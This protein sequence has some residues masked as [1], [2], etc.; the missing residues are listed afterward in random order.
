[1]MT[2]SQKFLISLD[3]RKAFE[4]AWRSHLVTCKPDASAFILQALLRGANPR[5]GFAPISNAVKLAN[6]QRAWQGYHAALSKLQR[7]L[8]EYVHCVWPALMGPGIGPT[9]FEA[10]VRD[11]AAL[12]DQLKQE[13]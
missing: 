1:M 5:A 10:I 9:R 3:E 7:R 13:V 12:I 11:L 8:A 2:H 6:G 4:L